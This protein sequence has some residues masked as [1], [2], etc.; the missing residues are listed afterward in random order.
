MKAPGVVSELTEL[1]LRWIKQTTL[2][3]LPASNCWYWIESV[4]PAVQFGV[5]RTRGHRQWYRY[6]WPGWRSK[7]G[8]WGSLCYGWL[9]LGGQ[10]PWLFRLASGDSS[11]TIC[12]RVLRSF[13]DVP[14]EGMLRLCRGVKI[15][16]LNPLVLKVHGKEIGV[17]VRSLVLPNRLCDVVIHKVPHIDGIPRHDWGYQNT[18][19]EW[20]DTVMLTRIQPAAN[21]GGS[22]F[23]FKAQGVSGYWEPCCEPCQCC[24]GS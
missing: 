23:G 1:L 17:R 13:G 9:W 12:F 24:P 22:S 11:F 15:L 4:K 19:G 6:G 20:E 2:M 18:P 16:L 14:W 7:Y 3:S 10:Y 5:S 8:N 21:K